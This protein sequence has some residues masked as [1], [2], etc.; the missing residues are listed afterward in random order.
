M[1]DMAKLGV[2]L[3]KALSEKNDLEND[4]NKVII[5]RE[6]LEKMT[7][8]QAI[9]A[10]CGYAFELENDVIGKGGGIFGYDF[11]FKVDSKKGN[12]ISMMCNYAGQ[13]KFDRYLAIS[14]GV[15][16]KLN[17]KISLPSLSKPEPKSIVIEDL[18]IAECP[19]RFKGFSG[20][21][22][23]PGEFPLTRVNFNGTTLP[24]NRLSIEGTNL[25]DRYVV[26]GDSPFQGKE[27]H[28]FQRNNHL[29][30][31]FSDGMEVWSFGEIKNE[32]FPVVSA[33]DIHEKFNQAAGDFIDTTPGGPPHPFKISIDSKNGISLSY[34]N[35]VPSKC[36]I[37]SF[38]DTEIHFRACIG[39]GPQPYSYKLIK[40]KVDEDWSL[41]VLN[42]ESG[43]PAGNP[44][45]MTLGGVK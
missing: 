11:K 31:C 44:L 26:V 45:K 33:E 41:L 8:A 5:S 21:L 7:T 34:P 18:T 36:L 13:G 27:L 37:T 22:A 35:M 2:A 42:G 24:V 28:L 3:G 19:R 17:P 40:S 38:L 32:D 4:S 29:Y 14:T 10:S 25:F 15:L 16:T 6:N 1:D 20:I 30:P 43:E 9:N 12:C 39:G 23:F